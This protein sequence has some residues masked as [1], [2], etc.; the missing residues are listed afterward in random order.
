MNFEESFAGK[1]VLITGGVGFIG[2]NLA[3]RLHT[4]GAQIVI[5]DSLIPQYGGNLHNLV[6]LDGR[7]KINISDI[8]DRHGIE[9]LVQGHD[10]IFNLAGQVSHLDSVED[11]VTDL[12]INTR[13]QVTL[14]EACRRHS[15][16]VKIVFASTRQI[17][18]R[19]EYLP[20]D[21]KH[22]VAPV[23]P[24]GINK[25]AGEY[26]HLLYSRI[27]GLKACSLRLTNCYGPRM[28]VVD[29]R[30]TFIGWW[31]RQ[32]IEGQEICV[33][34]D[35]E[36]LRDLNYIDDVVDAFLL[37]AASPVS[38]GEVYNL[39]AD[40]ISL[41]CLATL[42]VEL[43][44]SGSFR[45][46]PFPPERK[47]IDIGNFRADYRKISTRLG[48]KPQVPLREGLLHTLQFFRSHSE[49]YW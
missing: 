11:P 13:A 29:A 10:F 43:N 26:Y 6:G 38:H 20:V 4:L 40:P 3:H 24:N 17:Y 41:K 28:R 45:L 15:P 48:W 18:G 2:S 22:P 46:V 14:L 23:D 25:M 36:Q 30:Q 21:E 39:G 32:L 37:A 16:E 34:G 44:G 7:V 27:Y 49:H 42:M 5:V 1:R 31:F 47:A 12:E 8:R 9:Y 35:G 33:F 19:P